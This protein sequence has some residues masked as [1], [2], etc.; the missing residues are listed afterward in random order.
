MDIQI[1]QMVVEA[2]IV[3]RKKERALYELQNLKKR[4]DFIWRIDDYID[5]RFLVK[6]QS[7][8]TTYLDVYHMLKEYKVPDLCYIFSIDRSDDGT[9][10]PLKEALQRKVF[11]G[12]ALISC[13]HGKIAYFEG[14][15]DLK[16]TR[17]L[18]INKVGEQ[19]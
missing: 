3:K 5:E 9:S 1:E 2:F 8:I 10:M 19:L 13:D 18:I 12:P 15:M 16:P 6:V 4:H 11:L 14:E 7:P 17:Y